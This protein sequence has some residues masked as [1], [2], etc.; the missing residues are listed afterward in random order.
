MN[1]LFHY[2]LFIP[3]WTI[4]SIMNY[5]FHY[6]LRISIM[7]YIFHYELF[8][9]LWTIYS[10]MNYVSLLWTIYSIVNYLFHYIST[11]IIILGTPWHS[12]SS[13]LSCFSW[14]PWWLRFSTPINGSVEMGWGAAWT[15]SVLSLVWT[16]VIA[17]D[18][19]YHLKRS[20]TRQ[21]GCA[22]TLNISSPRVGII[23][24]NFIYLF[25]DY[26]VISPYNV[27]IISYVFSCILV[28]CIAV[29]CYFNLLWVYMY[30]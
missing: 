7:N 13:I 10:I 17:G 6:E 8:I 9:P 20:L 28:L 29:L 12:S 4:Y 16:R 15:S 3:L 2:E 23:L 14:M 5:L 25:I 26:Y 21:N 18:L 11:I 1:Y 24:V 27:C 19:P 22:L 30:V